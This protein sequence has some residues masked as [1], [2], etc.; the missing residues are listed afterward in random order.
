MKSKKVKFEQEKATKNTIRFAEIATDAPTIGM[1]YVQKLALKEI[2]WEEG[3]KIEVTLE[4][5]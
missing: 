1:L 5:N 4:V 2:G 3:Q